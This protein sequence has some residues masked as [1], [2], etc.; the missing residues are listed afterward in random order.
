M[1]STFDPDGVVARHGVG[2]VADTVDGTIKY[3]THAVASP[4][5]WRA[6]FAAAKCY[7]RE[8]HSSEASASKGSSVRW[9]PAV[10]PH[11]RGRPRPCPGLDDP[12]IYSHRFAE[13]KQGEADRPKPKVGEDTLEDVL[14]RQFRLNHYAGT[15]P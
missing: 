12:H 2:G 13:T 5:V 11:P 1:V 6:A 8:N 15:P 14:S 9:P 3:L 10:G 7:C 4:E